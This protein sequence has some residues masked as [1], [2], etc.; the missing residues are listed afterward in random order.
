MQGSCSAHPEYMQATDQPQL[1]HTASSWAA[2]QVEG[3]HLARVQTT[4]NQ[5]EG[6]HLARVQTT[7]GKIPAAKQRKRAATRC[8]K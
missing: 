7:T 2:H 6:P 3:P 8:K 1:R 4:T 5:V